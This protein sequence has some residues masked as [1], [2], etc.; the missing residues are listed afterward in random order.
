MYT[1][2]NHYAVQE[3]LP[4]HC[5]STITQQHFPHWKTTNLDH[6][7][8]IDNVLIKR[9][10]PLPGLRPLHVRA[11]RSCSPNSRF[12]APHSQPSPHPSHW[13]GPLGST[14]KRVLGQGEG[15][16]QT[17]QCRPAPGHFK[18]R[19]TSQNHRRQTTLTFQKS[20]S[21]AFRMREAERYCSGPAVYEDSGSRGSTSPGWLQIRCSLSRML[22]TS[23]K[24]PLFRASWVL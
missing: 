15:M 21:S 20:L 16:S 23:T 18:L 24:C 3:K 1:Y 14:P 11:L 5:K 19:L 2:N 13:A 4:Q 17:S 12:P 8:E 10:G 9:P 6:L 22:S 7:G